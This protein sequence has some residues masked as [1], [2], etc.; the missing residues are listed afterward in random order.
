MYIW[1]F[2]G[3]CSRPV[4]KLVGSGAIQKSFQPCT[5]WP[6]RCSPHP[7]GSPFSVCATCVSYR[8]TCYFLDCVRNTLRHHQ[9]LRA[10]VGHRVGFNC[11]HMIG[12]QMPTVYYALSM[13]GWLPRWTPL[14][15]SYSRV[16]AHRAPLRAYVE[17]V[18]L[19]LA[20]RTLWTDRQGRCLCPSVRCCC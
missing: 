20:P 6:S 8:C 16:G 11:W 15:S 14:T 4:D 13:I 18:K 3:D 19:K 7:S 2:I 1:S 17:T 10:L 5:V 12:G 9:P